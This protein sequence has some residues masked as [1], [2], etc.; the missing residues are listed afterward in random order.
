MLEQGITKEKLMFAVSQE[1]ASGNCMGIPIKGIKTFAKERKLFVIIAVKGE[2]QIEMLGNLQR[3]GIRN[4]IL[5]DDAF[6]KA[7]Q[8]SG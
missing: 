1:G 3:L 6:I 7:I 2:S 8:Q 4:V 5:T